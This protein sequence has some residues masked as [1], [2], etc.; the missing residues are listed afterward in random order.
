MRVSALQGI[1]KNT[2]SSTEISSIYVF[3]LIILGGKT[4]F[5]KTSS[6]L[7]ILL[8]DPDI[9]K[10]T[11]DCR[12][13]S[14]TLYHQFGVTLT[15][16]IELQILDQAVRIQG[17]ELPPEKSD[18]FTTSRVPYLSSMGKV[19]TRYALSSE[20]INIKTSSPHKSHAKIWMERPLLQAA[21]NYAANDVNS[22]R[23]QWNKMTGHISNLLKERVAIHSKR[24][25]SMF[26]KRKKEVNFLDK[27]FIMEEHALS[28]ESE[29][30]KDHP[31]YPI[32]TSIYTVLKWNRAINALQHR[33]SS[34][35]M[36]SYLF[37]NMM[38]GTP[39][40]EGKK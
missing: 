13:D 32:E 10:V 27:D 4:V 33:H 6:S 1:K 14:D 26:R 21:I 17:G 31:R 12:R 28:L 23:L 38:T 34:F 40:L 7:R 19:M 39:I 24:Y 9:T 2:K 29:L 36:M 37:F 30:P 20:M 18:Y 3:D 8:E 5:A 15:G 35:L 11:F 25:E 16:V 22:I